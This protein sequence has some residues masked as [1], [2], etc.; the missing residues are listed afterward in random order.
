MAAARSTRTTRTARS[1]Q[2]AEAAALAKAEQNAGRPQ[3]TPVPDLT[4]EATEPTLNDVLAEAIASQKQQPAPAPKPAPAPAPA[5]AP[6]P[7]PEPK[8]TATID[9]GAKPVTYWFPVATL[10]DGT[11]VACPHTKYGHESEK[12]ATACIKSVIASKGQKAA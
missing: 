10:A 7:K 3:L 2:N 11:K 6:Q 8:P 12:A 5:P 4:P 9:L 1:A